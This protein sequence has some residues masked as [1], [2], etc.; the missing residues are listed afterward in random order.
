MIQKW[1]EG[2]NSY[3]YSYVLHSPTAFLLV[4]S[5]YEL[6]TNA[7]Y[8]SLVNVTTIVNPYFL[9][10]WYKSDSKIEIFFH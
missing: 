4:Y 10:V 8:S 6:S 2:M 5:Y 3:P 7:I 9:S 1:N